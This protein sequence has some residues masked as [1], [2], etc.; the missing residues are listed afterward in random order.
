MTCYTITIFPEQGK[1]GKSTGRKYKTVAGA[2][3]RARELSMENASVMVQRADRDDDYP[4][5]FYIYSPLYTWEHGAIVRDYSTK[6]AVVGE[7]SE[8]RD[9]CLEAYDRARE[10]R[11]YAEQY[12]RKHGEHALRGNVLDEMRKREEAA[13]LAYLEARDML[14]AI[15]SA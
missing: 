7:A 10:G 15:I 8:R 4:E 1:P 5:E 12:A 11:V 9:R 13:R 3:R 2:N 6:S 14:N